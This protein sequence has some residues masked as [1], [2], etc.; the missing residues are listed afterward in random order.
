MATGKRRRLKAPVLSRLT[1][2]WMSVAG[3]VFA[4][5]AFAIAPMVTGHG[6]EKISLPVD[7]V[8]TLA[9]ANEPA[10]PTPSSDGGLRLAPPG[11]AEAPEQIAV[12]GDDISDILDYPAEFPT[13]TAMDEPPMMNPDDVI[14]TIAGGQNGVQRPTVASVQPVP[15][16]TAVADPHPDLLRATAFGK[17]P[18]I[19]PDGRKA[20]HFYR[21][22]YEGSDGRPQV[23]VIVGGL[24]LNAQLTEQAIDKLPPEISLSFAPYAKD[25]EFW[26]EKARKAGHEVIIELPMESYGGDAEALGTAGLLTSRTPAENL[27]RLD[28]LMSRFGG[29]FAATNYL[30]AKLA[31]DEEAFAP[32]LA[33]LRE[34]GVA[35][36]DDTGAALT[37]GPKVG[38]HVAAVDRV[39]PAALDDSARRRIR[40]ELKSLTTLA[41]R[42]GSAMAK[43]YAYT[44][45]IDEIAAWANDLAD[46][47]VALAPAS[48]ALPT[49]YASR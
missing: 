35:Y 8:E 15:R 22:G 43:T 18:K 33:R 4:V 1:F 40:R 36:I 17:I 46:S 25:L 7:G 32:I 29:Y 24:G 13:V 39:I 34:A 5:S 6:G 23:S 47:E 11:V 21:N 26:T 20:M 14:I 30:G 3:L 10:A 12:I 16:I 41:R 48:A 49:R 37:L 19:A 44:V 28:W 27:Q 31:A 38:A 9:R 45:A 42:E 2:A